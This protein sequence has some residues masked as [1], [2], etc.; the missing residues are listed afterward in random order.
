LLKCFSILAKCLFKNCQSAF[1]FEK[2]LAI[3]NW[4]FLKPISNCLL[5][6]RFSVLAKSTLAITAVLALL[7]QPVIART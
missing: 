3:T 5:L 6:K 4:F 2:N 7:K 1:I